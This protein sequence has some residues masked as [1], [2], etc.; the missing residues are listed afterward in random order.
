MDALFSSKEILNICV[1]VNFKNSF[2]P[3]ICLSIY[4]STVLL[5]NLGR[6]FSFL[7]L[8]TVGRTPWK[9]DQPIARP[10]PTHRTTE[11]QNKRTRT[12]MPQA[13]LEPTIPASEDSS[14]IRPRG[15]CD[16][17]KIPLLS[18]RSPSEL[19]SSVFAL[20]HENSI[21]LSHYLLKTVSKTLVEPQL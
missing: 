2:Y 1:P 5:L 18:N 12:S 19:Y 21:S 3:S 14:C 13:G 4:S 11:T 20:D 15:H 8:Y 10:L 17:L 16:R 6:F 7:I 9:G